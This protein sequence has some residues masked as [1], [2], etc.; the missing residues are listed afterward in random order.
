MLSRCPSRTTTWRPASPE[1]RRLHCRSRTPSRPMTTLRVPAPTRQTFCMN[2]P[3]AALRLLAPVRPPQAGRAPS[4][5]A[6]DRFGDEGVTRVGT[7]WR[8]VRHACGRRPAGREP[9]ERPRRVRLRATSRSRHRCNV[10]PAETSSK[11]PSSVVAAAKPVVEPAGMAT[12][13]TA[14]QVARRPAWAHD[15][16]RR[17]E[18]V[19]RALA[20]PR[21]RQAET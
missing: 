17:R 18:S 11:C 15:S 19:T 9:A 5:A 13:A 16:G 21:P 4:R 6:R 8:V 10:L 2:A 7:E 3:A 12:Y 1:Q 20:L 14:P